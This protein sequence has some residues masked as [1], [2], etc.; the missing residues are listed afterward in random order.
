MYCICH[1]QFPILIGSA[2]FGRANLLRGMFGWM[3]IVFQ[4]FGSAFA[5]QFDNTDGIVANV[6]LHLSPS[7]LAQRRDKQRDSDLA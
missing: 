1:R 3:T 5:C 2:G 7:A 4:G 6:K